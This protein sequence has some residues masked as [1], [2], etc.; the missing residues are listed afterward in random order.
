MEIVVVLSLNELGSKKKYKISSQ[1][2]ILQQNQQNI[3][4]LIAAPIIQK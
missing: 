4:L 1:E 3:F 2:I